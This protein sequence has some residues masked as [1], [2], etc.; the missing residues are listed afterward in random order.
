M[1]R[2]FITR[3]GPLPSN[4]VTDVRGGQEGAGASVTSPSASPIGSAGC[5]SL[6][7][8]LSAS[9]PRSLYPAA[10]EYIRYDRRR[11]WQCRP[12]AAERLDRIPGFGTAVDVAAS[13][14]VDG[15]RLHYNL[16]RRIRFS[17][18]R[19][20]FIGRQN[21]TNHTVNTETR[22]KAQYYITLECRPIYSSANLAGQIYN[23]LLFDSWPDRLSS[24][25]AGQ[26]VPN[27]C[28]SAGLHSTEVNEGPM[29]SICFRC[30]TDVIEKQFG[31]AFFTIQR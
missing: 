28:L 20:G 4:H 29:P 15:R 14:S 31:T 22:A 17:R 16:P 2:H 23:S 6:L 18:N 11:P 8:D 1:D 30:R 19:T 13:C 27:T 21:A 26:I 3:T 25:Q 9:S 7:I 10:S 24:R 5:V 12:L